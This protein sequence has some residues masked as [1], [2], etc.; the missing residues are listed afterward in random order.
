[1][2]NKIV[3]D[4]RTCTLQYDIKINTASRI[5]ADFINIFSA[6]IPRIIYI[7]YEPQFWNCHKVS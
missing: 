6:L 4:N 7:I 3:Q 2:K 5:F 1:M